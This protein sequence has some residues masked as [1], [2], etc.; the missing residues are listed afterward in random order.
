[1]T[2]INLDLK[3]LDLKMCAVWKEQQTLRLRFRLQCTAM[4]NPGTI[5]VHPNV[6]PL[7]RTPWFGCDLLN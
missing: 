3:T 4:A 5:L 7:V 2:T 6:I 1:M